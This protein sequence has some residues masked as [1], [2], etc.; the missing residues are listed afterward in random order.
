VTTL[1]E[2]RVV[3]ESDRATIVRST[4]DLLANTLTIELP[5]GARS[6]VDVVAARA[7]YMLLAEAVYGS[8]EP[9]GPYL[10]V[11]RNTGAGW[12]RDTRPTTSESHSTPGR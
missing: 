7:L 10:R 11:E 6:T 5:D 4:V 1:H 12:S 2:Y 8:L 9:S 3:A